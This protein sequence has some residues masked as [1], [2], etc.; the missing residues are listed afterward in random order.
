MH[1]MI[2]CWVSGMS[3][4]N[5]PISLYMLIQVDYLHVG[6]SP[7]FGGVPNVW[8]LVSS[9]LVHMC[10]HNVPPRF[11]YLFFH[12]RYFSL[13]GHRDAIL[14]CSMATL[15]VG[16]ARVPPLEGGLKC[17]E[18]EGPTC[19]CMPLQD[20][21]TKWH[22]AMQEEGKITGWAEGGSLTHE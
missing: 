1:L 20:G 10:V 19:S 2:F 16:C 8:D 3:M 21:P 13:N 22:L 7:S 17:G 4:R 18:E 14:Y 12:I 5:L 9:F 11:P 6:E 15:I